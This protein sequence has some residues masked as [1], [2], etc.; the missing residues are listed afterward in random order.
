[1]DMNE[2]DPRGLIR[3]S[4]RIK[5][6]SAP[7]CRSVFLDWALGVSGQNDFKLILKQLIDHYGAEFPRHPMTAILKEGLTDSQPKGRR[8]GRKARTKG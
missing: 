8:G 6:I 4:Y 5:G 2:L 1:M 7:E 3:E